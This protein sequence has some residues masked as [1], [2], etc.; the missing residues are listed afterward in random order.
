MERRE[1]D[2]CCQLFQGG[3]FGETCLQQLLGLTYGTMFN[4]RP[5][6]HWQAGMAIEQ[7]QHHLPPDRLLMQCRLRAFEQL[8]QLAQAAE[9]VRV[10]NQG[11]I[12][13]RQVHA[14]QSEFFQQAVQLRVVGIERPVAP[15]GLMAFVPVVHFVR[16]DQH[17]GAGA[18]KMF[19]PAIAIALGT[20]HDHADHKTIMH[21]GY[22]AVFDVAR[23]EQ[24]DTC[25]RW[26]LPEPD[27]LTL[28]AAHYADPGLRAASHCGIRRSR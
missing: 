13:G 7:R 25:Q 4:A 15:A 11:V 16:I 23:G 10:V 20:V 12:E 17:Q 14:R 18:S 28:L 2:R 9:Q 19:S 3:R 22:E 24:F 5:G 8:V 26:R 21:V 27:R 6:R 1:I